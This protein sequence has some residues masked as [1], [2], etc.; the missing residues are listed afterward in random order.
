[1][2]RLLAA[3]GTLAAC[4]LVATPLAAQGGARRDPYET[5]LSRAAAIPSAQAARPARPVALVPVS[6]ETHGLAG[7]VIGAV[8]GGVGFGLYVHQRCA[9]DQGGVRGDCAGPTTL[10]AVSGALAGALIGAMIGGSIS[11]SD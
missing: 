11:R 3:L 7:T 1:M 5:V 6:G 4:A 9:S 10:A 2:R 8:V